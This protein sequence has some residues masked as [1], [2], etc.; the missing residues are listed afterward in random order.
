MSDY[1]TQIAAAERKYGLPAG[2]LKGQMRTE[3]GGNPNA[4]SPKGAIGLMQIMPQT[5]ANLGVDP[6][7][8][9]Q[10]IDGA[11]RLMRDSL[12]SANGDA[13]MALRLYQGGP[14]QAGWG[15]QNHAY[16]ATVYSKMDGDTGHLMA[17]GLSGADASPPA[18][19]GA[20]S[21]P[22]DA[23]VDEHATLGAMG[24]SAADAPSDK[25]ELTIDVTGGHKP[26]ITFPF[27]TNP[28]AATRHVRE[29]FAKGADPADISTFI[30]QHGGTF[31]SPAEEQALYQN[32][33]TAGGTGSDP[34]YKQG[35]AKYPND[36]PFTV[37]VSPEQVSGGDAAATGLRNFGSL[38]WN[39]EAVAYLRSK[40]GLSADGSKP[41]SQ[42]GETP[43]QVY[44]N[45]LT[46][47]R[48]HSDTA[49]DQHPYAY[50]AGAGVG[51]LPQMA[52][53]PG[54]TIPKMAASNALIGGVSGAGNATDGNRLT[55][56]AIGVGVGAGL[57]PLGA[58]VGAVTSK[59]R[60]A[61]APAVDPAIAALAE[62]AATYGIN[63]RGSQ[64]SSSPS[65]HIAD[66]LLSRMPGAGIAAD[67]VAQRTAFTRAVGDTF[68]A[69][70]DTLTPAV[71][72]AAKERIGNVYDTVGART[73]LD[74]NPESGSPF[75]DNISKI[76]ADARG[77]VGTD[78]QPAVEHLVTNILDKVRPDGTMSGTA[79]KALTS[80]GTMLDRAAS[81]SDP[82]F[83]SVAKGLKAELN[84]ALT[85]SA[86]P[87]DA[88]ALK[89]A[90]LQWKNMRTVEKLTANSTDGTISPA[91]L[92]SRV[93]GSFKNRAYTGAGDLGELG[94]IGQRF[95]K[96]PSTSNTAEHNALIKF[97]ANAGKVAGTLGT[98]ILGIKS[99]LTPAEMMMMV[100]GG[101]GTLGA[102][103]V[104]GGMLMAPSYRN[105]LI[106]SAL[107]DHGASAMP[108]QTRN[109]LPPATIIANK[110]LPSPKA[111]QR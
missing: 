28:D 56:G 82:S 45:A 40:I 21:P 41:A 96:S 4:R 74:L 81:S 7:D 78:K 104:A 108:F 65:M 101:A 75:V 64:I 62:R 8:P 59:A 44:N 14:N 22:Q 77:V 13:T 20:P 43:D 102:G 31:S 34:R 19:E 111:V 16:P 42:S 99:G 12:K 26:E 2:M 84:D 94:D 95:L 83:A 39:D 72:Q 33:E 86:T 38:G 47:E 90:N 37:A 97:G 53:A 93:T 68:G 107:N 80:R 49:W 52:L 70:S 60:N 29:L 48:Q 88:A 46:M 32:Y 61:L 25:S 1:D 51:M 109:F 66:G 67:N 91:L 30:K 76:A 106:E 105:R 27:G 35:L 9:V 110:L 58:G 98:A 57:A 24:F 85:A 50:A 89:Q 17:M 87:E 69:N 63:L 79:F 73:H 54:S 23:K 15:A 3:S 5:A 18:A 36:S 11:A 55:A 100:G 71:M 10:S 6:T 92:Q 103:K